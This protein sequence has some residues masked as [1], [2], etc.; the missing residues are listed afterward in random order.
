ML[1]NKSAIGPVVA[2]ALLLVVSVLAVVGFQSWFQTYSSSTFSDVETQSN[3]NLGNSQIETIVG[4][5]LYFKN[6]DSN[7]ITIT[8]VKIDGVDCNVTGNFSTGMKDL[9]ISAC[10]YNITSQTPEIVVVT[11]NGIFQEKTYLKELPIKPVEVPNY[12]ISVWNTSELVGSITNDTTVQLPIYSGGTYNFTVEGPTLVGSPVH[13]TSYLNR[14]LTFTTPGVHEINISGEIKGFRFNNAGD[15]EKLYDIK[16]WG[17]LNVGNLGG[18][19]Y[20][21]SNL[22][23]TATDNLNLTGTTNLG[24]MFYMAIN[25]NGSIGNWDTSEVN[26]M[27]GLLFNADSFTQS[28]SSWNVSLVQNMQ[29]MFYSAENYNDD[30]S[31]WDTSS[32]TTMNWMFGVANSF[33]SNISSWNVSSVTSMVEMFYYNTAFNQNLSSWDVNQV[34]SCSDFNTSTTSWEI[35]N[36]P[37]FAGQGSTCTP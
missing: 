26:Y 28:I 2:I 22:I 1:K 35:S 31:M 11:N 13:I 27:F 15:K 5:S 21:C 6:G 19:F 12:F 33:N 7:N 4:E 37:D 24:S 25:F 17:V 18:Y 14:N 34:T 30:L 32:V 23:G 20:G 10:V 36:Q 8:S 3:S 9:N 16:Q 29:Y